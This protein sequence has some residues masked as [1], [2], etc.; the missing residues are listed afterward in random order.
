M[1]DERKSD[2][3]IPTF[4]YPRGKI[5]IPRCRYESKIKMHLLHLFFM[6]CTDL[7]AFAA[8]CTVFSDVKINLFFSS[9]KM[10]VKIYF[11]QNVSLLC[12]FVKNN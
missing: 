10:G 12:E 6:H 1:N 8:F 9:V 7:R 3:T 2:R 11:Q 4:P 5:R